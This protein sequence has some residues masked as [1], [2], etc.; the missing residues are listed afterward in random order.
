MKFLSSIAFIGLMFF[1]SAQQ[2]PLKRK[3]A[4]GVMF[5]AV[6]DSIAKANNLKTTEG[7]YMRNVI[8]GST[9]EKLGLQSGDILVKLN[10]I[11]LN[12]TADIINEI[13]KYRAGDELNV[14]YYRKGKMQIVTGKAQPKPKEECDI[15]EVVYGEVNYPGSRLRTILYTPL[16]AT[17]PPVVFYIQGYTCQSVDLPYSADNPLMKLIRDWVAAGFAVYRIEKPGMG[18][19]ESDK[20]CFELNFAEEVEI[21]KQGFTDLQS[22]NNIDAENIFL[23]GHSIGGIIAPVVA[24]AFSPKGVITYGTVVNTWFEYMQELSRVQGVYFERPDVEVEMDVRNATPFWY[25]MLIEQKSNTEILKDEKIVEMLESEGTLESFK[26]GQFINRHYSYWA[27]IQQLNLSNYWAQ[28]S[29]DVLAIYGEFDIQALHADHIYAIQRIVNS[30]HPGKATAV[31]VPGA[32]HGFV[33]FGSMS[34]NVQSLNTNTYGRYAREHYHE[35]VAKT[36]VQWMNSI[37]HP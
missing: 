35:G 3:A 29:A 13:G 6:N 12:T 20:P 1:T 7:L 24:T 16:G 22:Q 4:L 2:G 31:V 36:T 18:D 33:R 17:K 21:F 30:K 32:D 26:A 8:N 37:L 10:G 9:A 23:F 19:S 5:E 25:Q 27:G 14:T 34:E 28:V 11:R 15:A